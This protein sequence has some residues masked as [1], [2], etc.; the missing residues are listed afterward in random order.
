MDRRTSEDVQNIVSEFVRENPRLEFTDTAD[1]TESK[2]AEA[3]EQNLAD[4]YRKH[5]GILNPN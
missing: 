2:E 5:L 3:L 4:I 1:L